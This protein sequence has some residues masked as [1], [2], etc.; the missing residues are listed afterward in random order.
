[1]FYPIE[2]NAEPTWLL[3][4]IR[5]QVPVSHRLL[6]LQQE[7]QNEVNVNSRN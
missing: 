5:L 1:V 2:K 4:C 3:I 6:P 7:K